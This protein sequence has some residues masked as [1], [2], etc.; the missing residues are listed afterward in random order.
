MRHLMLKL[1][2][3]VNETKTRV[4]H[5]PEDTFDFLGYTIGRCYSPKTG[6]AY[7]GTRPSKGSVRRICRQI[8]EL[9]DRR[10]YWQAAEERVSRLN[11]LLVGW[12]NYFCLGPVSPAYRAVDR[13]A[14]R[15]LRRWLC[16]KHKVRGRG[17]SRFPDEY[18]YQRL[19]LVMLR[20][21]TRNFP[22]AKA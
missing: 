18:L 9:T 21:R 13:H 1:K 20:T 5:L 16:R 7:L 10:W 6:R 22:W 17:I 8:R 15:R 2:L 12:S 11:R 14:S 19:H 4:C 3:T